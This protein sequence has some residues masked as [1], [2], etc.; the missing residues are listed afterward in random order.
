M[1]RDHPPDRLRELGL[2]A[3]P[4]RARRDR[5]IA[6]TVWLLGVLALYSVPVLPRDL[7]A[8]PPP[9]AVLA[10]IVGFLLWQALLVRLVTRSAA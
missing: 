5:R 8:E 6:L 10:A 7:V 1:L 4:G 9:A 2:T 3:R